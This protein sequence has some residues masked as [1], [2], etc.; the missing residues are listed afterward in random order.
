MKISI[1]RKDDIEKVFSMK[2]AIQASKDSLEIY[3]KGESDI[4]LR[5]ILNVD[6]Q[7]AE[8]IYMP[9]YAAGAN[10]LGIKIVSVFPNN[11][12]KGLNTIPATM[13]LVDE[14]TGEVSSLIDG[15]Y[16]TQIRTGA[17]SGAATDLLARK[18]SK[19]FTIIGTGGQAPSQIEA[20]LDV[21]N[22]EIV[23]IYNRKIA[24]AEQFAREMS[25]KLISKY[26]I[27]I[28]AAHSIEEAISDADIITTATTS[29]S[30]VF[31]GKLVKK[32]AHINAV[33]SFK[34]D[35]QEID[36]YTLLNADKIYLDTRDGVLHESGDF[37]IPIANGSFKADDIT[38]ELGELISKKI[39]SRENDSEITLFKTVG[40][41]ILDIV[42]AR[43]IYENAKKEN[44]GQI[45]EF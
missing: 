11:N 44:I 31:D 14:E 40:S 21:R 9:G 18:D 13:V 20:V 36:E 42:T 38:G 45:I 10:A 7:D 6:V 33:G 17:I 1:L 19:I 43:R 37:L 29:K 25:D 32:G 26:N 15:T 8:S 12:E 2:D 30:P 22:I 5:T 34:P 16:L 27:K 4:P 3:S 41:S 24:K 35:M 28:I 23:K 39:P